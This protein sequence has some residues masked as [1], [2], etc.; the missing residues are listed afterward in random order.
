MEKEIEKLVENFLADFDALRF[1][2][3]RRF[4]SEGSKLIMIIP[5]VGRIKGIDAYLEY[6]SSS[7]KISNRS[8][9]WQERSV[10]LFGDVARVMGLLRMTFSVGDERRE[11]L[12][13]VTF[14]LE[15]D[16]KNEWKCFHLQA[17]L[18]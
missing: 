2:G 7:T 14:L 16:S 13:Y 15:R 18:A 3:Y 4:F 12:E 17:T 6:E 5:R 11:L 8:T 1:E 10:E 9:S